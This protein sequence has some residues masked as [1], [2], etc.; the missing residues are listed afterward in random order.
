MRKP[1]GAEVRIGNLSFT[2]FGLVREGNREWRV[3]TK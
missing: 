1:G 2:D 3:K